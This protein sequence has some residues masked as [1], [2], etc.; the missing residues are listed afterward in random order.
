[1]ENNTLSMSEAKALANKST[2]ENAGKRFST[3]AGVIGVI[4]ADLSPRGKPQAELTCSEA[5]CTETHVREISDWHQCGKC[6]TH[7]KSKSRSGGGSSTGSSVTAG[8]LRIMKVLDTDTDEVKALKQENNELVEQL[9]AQEKVER[10]A[11]KAK[12]AEERKAKQE[13][14]KQER[15]AKKAAEQAQKLRENMDRIK[16]VAAAKGLPVSP[17]TLAE[18]GEA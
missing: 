5:G 2:A 12:A 14:E 7:K 18:A 15:E 13:Q 6:R 9:L 11:Q 8:G 17:K 4:L 1:M 16:A 10:E 3:P